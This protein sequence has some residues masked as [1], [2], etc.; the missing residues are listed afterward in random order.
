ML[1]ELLYLDTNRLDNYV[2]RV[3]GSAETADKTRRI[4]AEFSLTGPKVSFNQ[5][6]RFRSLTNEEKISRL[7]EELRRKGKLS[8]RRPNDKWAD[9]EFVLEHFEGIRVVVPQNAE[10]QKAT[11]AFGFWLS[12]GTENDGMLCLLEDCR[13]DDDV[14]YNYVRLSAYTVLQSLVYFARAQVRM[15][16]L[17]TYISDEDHPNPYAKV[18]ETHPPSLVHEFHNVK[19]FLNDFVKSPVELL[20]KWGCIVS[21]PR[22]VY[23]LYRVREYGPEAAQSEAKVTTFAYPVYIYSEAP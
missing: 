20:T 11:P 12:L 1:D 19:T 21:H 5:E 18:N 23:S 13:S 3:Y 9:V 7:E 2:E 14:P 22:R 6:Q 4:G 8:V 16:I 10:P 15:S 17:A